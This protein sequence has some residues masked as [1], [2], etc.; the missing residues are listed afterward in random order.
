MNRLAWRI[1][2][3]ELAGGV[4]G[5][6]IYLA[7]IALGVFAIAA[8][9]S[10]TEGF[11]RGLDAEARILLGG[12]AVF[13]AA[14]RRAKPSELDWIKA[15]GDISEEIDVNVMGNAGDVRRQV[16]LRAVDEAHPLIGTPELSG[17]AE[18]LS[19]ALA[20]ENGRWGIAASASLLE[21]FELKVGD[22]IQL[23]RINAT[24]RA[25][26]D[27]ESDGIGAPGTFGPQ[28]TIR[29]GALEE[30]G[31][32]T[33]GQLFRASYRLVLDDPGMTGKA[34]EDAAEAE[35]GS[36]GLRYRGPEDAID[37]LEQLLAMLE[38]F[39][40]VIGIA[41]LIAGGVGIAQA[42]TAFLA[43]RIP[44][45]AAFK[46]L[47]AEA[48]TIRLA[49]L[50][51]LGGLA[52]FGAVIGVV[53]GAAAPFLLAAF[54]GDRIP[55]PTIL[56]LYPYP[57]IRAILLG[58]L[59]AA[60]FALPPIGKARATRP[61]ALF[62]TL[63]ADD[64]SDTPW[65]ERIGSI[66][67]AIALVL[68]AVLTSGAPIVTVSL[69]VGAGIAWAVLLAMAQGIRILARRTS[70]GATG[71]GRLALSNLGGPG[72]L[73]PTITPA[74]GLGL[75]LLVFV[76]SVQANILRQVNETA[77]ANL[78]SLVFSQIPNVK[79]EAFDAFMAAQDIDI[80]DQ[81]V[82]Q[83]SPL[84]IGRVV[85]L[86]G[87][88]LDVEKV[89]R[90]ERWVV[91]GETA[92]PYVAK[93]PPNLELSEG[94]WWPDD[95]SG[96]LL[97]SVEAD[98]AKGLGIGIGDT[99]GFRIF[100]RQ[101]TATVASLRTVDWG[102]FG[103]NSAFLMS[104]GTLEAAQPVN[105]AILRTSPDREQPIIEKLGE[106][107]PEVVVFQTREALAAASRILGNISIA[108]NAA[109]GIVLLAGLMVLIG[110]FA[111]MARKRRAESALL[112]TLG[113]SRGSILGLYATEFALA[114]GVAALFGAAMGVGAAWP[115]VT[116]QFEAE[117]TMPWATVGAVS[118]IAIFAAAIGGLVVG[119][120]TLSHPPARVL[121]TA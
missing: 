20:Y 64:Q 6:R 105:V 4:S 79:A 66:I 50:L 75:A 80:D 91:D 121:R 99:V 115:I 19:D 17:G 71:F 32:L 97:T 83:R 111:A 108:I 101:V 81:D 1:A 42:S 45:I 9:G 35:W 86:K 65:A 77:T 107:F 85:S 102:G 37:G 31:R 100:G 119:V 33:D 14:Q 34:L 18:T 106:E 63:G 53:L 116:Q 25:Q 5:F 120:A 28:A 2:L 87:K 23:G 47:G 61:A 30:A 16:D 114:G 48:G 112:K 55:L 90:S 104:P 82:F 39:L 21:D 88:P 78:P 113:A 96:P 22:D 68:L 40:S 41:A 12:D 44:S 84:V 76:A 62:R 29:I 27:K 95:Y 69:L 36:G 13:T 92:M 117:W 72:S 58:L 93:R 26:L 38:S 8:A 7:C 110:A 59:A 98:A 56:Q 94:E 67:A 15:R 46:A 103:P 70:G 109:A 52:L 49:Y 43:S 73:A 24:I 54:V 11:S 60:I 118:S 74:L 57:L 10:V 3:R 51:Q 89:A